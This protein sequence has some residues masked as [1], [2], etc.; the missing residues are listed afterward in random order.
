VSRTLR[1]FALVAVVAALGLASAGPAFAITI[2]QWTF[3]APN[4]PADQ[5]NTALSA[6]VMAGGGVFAGTSFAQGRHTNVNTDYSTPDGNGSANSFSAN[7]WTA[8]GDNWQFQTSTVGFN[9]ISIMFDQTR[10]STGPSA[11]R[12]DVSLDGVNFQTAVQGYTVLENVA[13]N[14]GVWNATTRF[15]NYQFNFALNG[16]QLDLANQTMVFIRLVSTATAAG[17]GTNRVDNVTIMGDAIPGP[18]GAIPEPASLSLLALGL[19]AAA[20]RARRRKA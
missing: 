3:E 14:G 16:S 11:F 4:T 6:T 20:V 15:A 9:N 12:I 1:T 7:N 13:G 8:I 5:D 17:G 2:A 19:G 18:G 10:S